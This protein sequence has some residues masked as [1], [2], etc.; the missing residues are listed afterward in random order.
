MTLKMFL[1]IL[2]LDQLAL[3]QACMKLMLNSDNNDY[4]YFLLLQKRTCLRVLVAS[5]PA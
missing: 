4:L 5:T 1:D 2:L 3:V